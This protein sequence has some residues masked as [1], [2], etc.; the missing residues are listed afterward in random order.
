MPRSFIAMGNFSSHRGQ[1]A[2]NHPDSGI[3]TESRI[4][5]LTVRNRHWIYETHLW[6]RCRSLLG[7]RETRGLL[8][9]KICAVSG[10]CLSN[11][12]DKKLQS[13][14]GWAFSGRHLTQR[15]PTSFP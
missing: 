8:D 14:V 15:Y 7:Q 6:L 4:R 3:V 11:P 5:N 2:S 10:F 13:G 9:A 12:W 1:A